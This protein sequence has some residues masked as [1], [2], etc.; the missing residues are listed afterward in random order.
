MVPI[1]ITTEKIN[2]VV[3]ECEIIAELIA[4][5]GCRV[6]LRKK[7]CSPEELD[8]MCSTLI[9]CGVDKEFVTLHG[10]RDLLEKYQFGGFHIN[11]ECRF[12]DINGYRLSASCHTIEEVENISSKVDYLFL[13]PIFDSISKHG[14][15]SQ[16]KP[17]VLKKWLENRHSK[18]K[19]IALGGIDEYNINS[20]YEWGF[21]GA[22][23]LGAI[24]NCEDPIKKYENI[25][26]SI[27]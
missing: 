18:T 27:K 20:T 1:V 8:V 15:M 17:E 5:Y 26:N 16:H 25:I 10:Y 3:W 4:R 6:H 7:E 11:K 24:W 21:D 22:A 9:K 2:N 14:Y 12:D 23:L 13:S 19:I